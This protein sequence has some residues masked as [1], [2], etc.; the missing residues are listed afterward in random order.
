M[1]QLPSNYPR[2]GFDDVDE[3]EIQQID[4]RIPANEYTRPRVPSRSEPVHDEEFQATVT[5]A[6]KASESGR[7]TEPA[8]PP[9]SKRNSTS[10]F[11][12][13]DIDP[14]KSDEPP[15]PVD[16]PKFNTDPYTVNR[17]R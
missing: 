11:G 1:N 8:A 7:G 12:L 5:R 4:P 14:P 10:I 9:P 17:L 3:P 16:P 13:E 2:E 15:K 6:V